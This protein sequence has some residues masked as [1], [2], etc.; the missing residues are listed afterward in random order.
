MPF[1]ALVYIITAKMAVCYL[2][3]MAEG[4]NETLRLR[5]TINLS[6]LFHEQS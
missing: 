3:Y 5:F 6:C 4:E 1:I 2:Q